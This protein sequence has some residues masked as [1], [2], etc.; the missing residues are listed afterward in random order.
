[1]LSCPTHTLAVT[2]KSVC[3]MEPASDKLMLTSR[4]LARGTSRILLLR[5]KS[6]PVV[7]DAD[8]LPPPAPASYSAPTTTST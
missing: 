8:T 6:I 5:S 4:S 7:N 2:D 1:M 3:P